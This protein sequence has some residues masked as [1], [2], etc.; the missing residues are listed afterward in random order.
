MFIDIK[1]KIYG[2]EIRKILA[3][4]VFDSSSSGLD[5]LTL[6]YERHMGWQLYGWSENDRIIAVCG[7]EAHDDWVEILHIAVRAD[8]R[9]RGI[10]GKIVAALKDMYG[11]NIEAETDDDAVD[12]YRKCG[13]EATPI[14]KYDMQRWACV[15]F[16]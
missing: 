1:P 14:K 2:T 6:D 11:M 7:F 9:H 3:E 15:L 5:K 16:I 12:F 13:F 8:A 4:C 10:G